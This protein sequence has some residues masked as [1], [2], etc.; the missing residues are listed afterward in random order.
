METWRVSCDY[1]KDLGYHKTTR[2]HTELRRHSVRA[3]RG[4]K[5]R[6]YA[7]RWWY[8]EIVNW[9]TKYTYSS[10]RKPRRQ[11]W[12]WR[13]HGHKARETGAQRDM[14]HRTTQVLKRLS[15]LFSAPRTS[16]EPST[17]STAMPYFA[18]VQPYALRHPNKTQGHE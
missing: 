9:S 15:V 16:R 18:R 3:S 14:V 2:C 17:E 11:Y 12:N 1:P 4:L 7:V 8:I 5:Q 6:R 10:V 13:K